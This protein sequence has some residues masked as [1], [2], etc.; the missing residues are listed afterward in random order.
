MLNVRDVIHSA[1]KA[2][3]KKAAIGQDITIENFT[4]EDK[5][6]HELIDDIG[7]I[8]KKNKKDLL[9]VGIDT[10]ENERSGSFLQFDQSNIYSNINSDSVELMNLESAIDKYDW[11]KDYLW[12]AVQP[13][14]DKYTARTALREQEEDVKSGYFVR[15]LPGTKEIFPIQTCM[16][17]ADENVMQTAHNVII[18][19]EN[20][21]LHLITGCA[22]GDDVASALH[23]GVSE[24]Y[25]KPGAKITFTMVH[26]W[27]EQVE[28]R[29]RTGIR[30]GDDST[31]INNYILTSPV[32]TIQSY[33]TA[34]CDGKNSRAVFQSIQ[35]GHK[36][37]IID[38]GSRVLLNGEGSAAEV[39]SRA[40]SHDESKIYS[41]GHLA[42]LVPGVRG[43]LECHGLVLSDDSMIY[44][45]PELEA[46]AAN[47]EMSHEA[48]VGKIDE[49]EIYYLTSRGLT[50]EEATSMI[51][52]GFLSMDITG[53]PDE[54]ANETQR[55]IDMSLEGM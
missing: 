32:K 53:L 35:S 5:S 44:A 22:T 23:V 43:H 24:F 8:S 33:P 49:D 31:Y 50:E 4:K 30:L 19:E 13:D 42:G 48:A 34:Y 27:A 36:D 11:V 47:L 21:E 17:I 28:V 14:A 52:R 41:R 9:K 51:V 39:I 10:E 2:K 55:M 38:V 20:S 1:E 16:F 37:S 40:V 29:P 15:S 25:L 54:L 18:A 26:N 12:Q 7:D 46:S 45:V 6:A 3:N